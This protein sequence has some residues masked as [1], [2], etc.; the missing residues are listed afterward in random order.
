MGSVTFKKTRETKAASDLAFKIVA[1]ELLNRRWS[2]AV[3]CD[4]KGL[5]V[6]SSNWPFVSCASHVAVPAMRK[7]SANMMQTK[8]D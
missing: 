1:S 7:L 3:I 4:V 2:R 5:S 8:R 6:D